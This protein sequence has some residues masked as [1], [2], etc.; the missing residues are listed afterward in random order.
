MADRAT[1]IDSRS[2]AERLPES[3]SPKEI[4]VLAARLNELLARLEGSFQCERRMTANLA[5]ELRTPIAELGVASDLARRWS[6]DPELQSSLA[7]TAH[8]VAGR[9]GRIVANL[10]HLA[11]VE[12]GS[13]SLLVEKTVVADLVRQAFA[14]LAP[15]VDGRELECVEQPQGLEVAV[16]RALLGVVINNLAENA[17]RH[18]P[19]GERIRSEIRADGARW[20]WSLANRTPDLQRRDLE[21]LTEAFWRKDDVRSRRNGTGLGL[22]I[23]RA[24]VD[25]MG[26]SLEFT[27]EDGL[28]RATVRLSPDRAGF[29]LPD[30][31]HLQVT[32]PT[33]TRAR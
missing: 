4:A 33:A 14:D 7:Q 28:F 5:H 15:L 22:A 9:M 23:A 18:S 29:P 13:E 20:E 31:A 1:R 3:G 12:A 17:L 6:D 10:L 2:L 30:A 21:H 25:V 16:D 24:A 8:E 27:L 19:R 11:R 26:G 32:P